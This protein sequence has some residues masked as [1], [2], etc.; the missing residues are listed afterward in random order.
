MMDEA[1]PWHL[2]GWSGAAILLSAMLGS[3][4][5][6]ALLLPFLRRHALSVPTA[7]SSHKGLTP[8]GGGIPVVLVTS[9]VSAVAIFAS[10]QSELPG[11]V[12][13]VLCAVL[14]LGITGAFDDLRNLSPA[15]RLLAQAIAVAMVLA[16]L[17]SETRLVPAYPL[18]LE[19]GLLLVGGIWFVNLFNFMDGID[20]I[21]V[22]EVV[23]ITSG[24]ALIGTIDTLPSEALVVALALNG[25]MIGFA[26]FNRPVAQLFLGD[27]GSLPIGLL[28]GWLLLQV[29]RSGHMAAAFLLPLYFVADATVTLVRRL[30][31]R[32]RV[33]EAHR[34]HFYQRAR[35]NGFSTMEIVGRVFGVNCVLVALAA[36]SVVTTSSVGK[37]SEVAVGMVLV[38]WLM[39]SFARRP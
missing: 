39:A 6:S 24:V 26:P 7:R 4:G 33:W 22:A 19:R 35:D 31:A 30:F 1:Y 12:F 28:V 36:M 34:T 9:A 27:V 25:A 38:G 3:A 32:E 10:S 2:I 5:L 17:P 8:Q 11:D 15:A 21:V 23:P 37:A 13:L 16:A 18:W 20:W 14:L 29:A